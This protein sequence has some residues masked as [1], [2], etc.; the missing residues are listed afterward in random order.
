MKALKSPSSTLKGGDRDQ[1]LKQWNALYPFIEKIIKA[2]HW[3]H[4]KSSGCVQIQDNS[5]K[6]EFLTCDQ[7]R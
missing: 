2:E 4:V 1:L 3:D 6:A 5:M 7:C